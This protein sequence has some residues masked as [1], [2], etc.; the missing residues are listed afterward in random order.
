MTKNIIV[1]AL[2]EKNGKFFV[3]KRMD[4]SKHLPGKWEFPGGKVEP[5]ET[6]LEALE[7]KITEDFNTII[8]VGKLVAVTDIDDDS[9]VHL[10]KATHNLGSYRLTLHSDSAWLTLK[11]I[12]A[13]DLAPANL[14]LLDQILKDKRPTA[15]HELEKGRS[16][17]NVD[18]SRIFLVS[19]QGG[20][21]KSKRANSLI[22]FALHNTNN[23]YEDK[24]GQDGI[25]HYTGMGLTGDQ[26]VD[27]RRNKTL[28]ESRQ[29]GIDVH[30]FESF[31]SNEYIYRG[32]V[33][34][35]SGPYYE[36]QKDEDGHNRQV[37]KF[38]LRV[39][40]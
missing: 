39:V 19:T 31:E 5:G 25:M 2:I 7:R 29:S 23:P 30:L 33:E 26:S 34:L 14:Q 1:A 38:P 20:M 40:E 13:L 37:V 8:N 24:W 9:S 35:A 11:E 22:L 3:V 16:Y 10:Y 12:A 21:R 27:Y 6:E 4:S 36:S 32:Q 28:A 18:I 15:L 17:K